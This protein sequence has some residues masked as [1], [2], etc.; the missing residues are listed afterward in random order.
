MSKRIVVPAAGQTT[1]ELTLLRWWVKEG[2]VVRRGQVIAELETDKSVM[3]L[4]S[5]HA[6]MVLRLHAR[7][8]EVVPVGATL[9]E[10]GE[11][12]EAVAPNGGS[13]AAGPTRVAGSAAGAA[14]KRSRAGKPA[15]RVVVPAAGQTSDELKL[16]RWRVALGEDVR[17]GQILCELETDKSVMELESVHQGQVLKRVAQEGTTVMVGSTLMYVGSPG[18]QIADDEEVSVGGELAGNFDA[19]ASRE[20]AT[21]GIA[22]GRSSG[23][24]ATPAARTLARQEALNLTEI[25]GH[26]P[27]GC[28]VLANVKARASQTPG[29]PVLIRG[30][31]EPLSRMR[32]TIARRLVQS[33]REAPHFHVAME[34][35]V[36]RLLAARVELNRQAVEADRISINDMIVKTAAD[37]L[38]EHPELNCSYEEDAIH[39]HEAIHIGIA[40]RVDQGLVVPVLTDVDRLTLREVSRGT[41]RLIADARAGKVDASVRSTFTVSN[42]GMYGVRAFTAIINPPE[43][44]ILAIGGIDDKLVMREKAIEA[45]PTLIVTL[46]ADHRVVDGDLAARFLVSLRERISRFEAV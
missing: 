32:Q 46:S 11:P 4:E 42:L 37:T 25:T 6:G 34:I 1:D 13:D 21:D 8:G 29:G 14:P 18:D 10:L 28:I 24:L 41:K 36:S 5:I 35:D 27:A 45:V 43:A 31:R 2:D 9:M 15:S 12:G 20:R 40:V 23:L 16:L 22:S 44:A 3:E 38:V 17:P 30:R 33:V 7:E 19:T 39:Y 26:G